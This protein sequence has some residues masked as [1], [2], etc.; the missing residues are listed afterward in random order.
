MARKYRIP[1]PVGYVTGAK[2][3]EHLRGG[4]KWPTL[5]PQPT[6]KQFIAPGKRP[7]GKKPSGAQGYK[8]TG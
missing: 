3:G 6:P 2:L 5:P 4:V 7:P 8:G 1:N